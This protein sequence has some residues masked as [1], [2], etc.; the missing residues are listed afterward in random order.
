MPYYNSTTGF[1]IIYYIL[2]IR[3]TD[4]GHDDVQRYKAFSFETNG[5]VSA[6]AVATRKLFIVSINP[7]PDTGQSL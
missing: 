3:L 6:Y 5:N 7:C 1:K 2:Y 4:F